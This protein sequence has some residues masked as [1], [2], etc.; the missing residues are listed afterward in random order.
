[1]DLHPTAGCNKNPR[2]LQIGS[3]AF[4][5]GCDAGARLTCFGPNSSDIAAFETG[6]SPNRLASALLQ[7]VA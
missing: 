7:R 2:K 3:P 6:L 1:M 5:K 4:A